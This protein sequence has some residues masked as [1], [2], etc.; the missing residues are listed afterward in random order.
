MPEMRGVWSG[1]GEKEEKKTEQTN[2]RL[3]FVVC[4]FLAALGPHFPFFSFFF[5][6][7][8]AALLVFAITVLVSTAVAVVCVV[9][10]IWAYNAYRG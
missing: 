6:L 9:Y 3:R 2:T 5:K 4:W 7:P 10:S 8:A 1:A